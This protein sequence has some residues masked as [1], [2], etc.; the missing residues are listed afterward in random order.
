VNPVMS[1][2][3]YFPRTPVIGLLLL[4]LLLCGC[5]RAA[6]PAGAGGSSSMESRSMTVAGVRRE[7]DLLVPASAGDGPAPLVIVFHGGTGNPARMARQTG[8]NPVAREHGFAVAYPAS[9][10]HW[11][12]G[13]STTSGFGD[14]VAFARALV[15]ALV[16][17]GVADPGRIYA[18]GASNGGMMTLRL[19]CEAS[20]LFAAFAPVIASFPEPYAPRCAPEEAVHIL[21]INGTLDRLI[22]WRGGSILKGRRRGVGGTVV[23]VGDTLDF[24]LEHNG[25]LAPEVE[26]LPDEAPSDGTRVY[27][28]QGLSCEQGS[29]ALL[30]VEGG[31]HTWPGSS[32]E[33]NAL[34]GRVSQ[35]ISATE[36]I[37]RFFRDKSR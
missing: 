7:Y 20:D 18:T 1:K 16:E 37:W 15:A 21:M 6:G 36:V 11:N 4:G 34:A 3:T 2:L 12:D 24:W 19:A 22:K 5:G 14:D 33:P 25:C 30:R 26:A 29:V 23:P 27:R 8:F 32:V 31:G 10:T 9:I 17:E 13:R 35:D 28:E